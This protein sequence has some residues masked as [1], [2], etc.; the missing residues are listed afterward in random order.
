MLTCPC[1][2]AHRTTVQNAR[3]DVMIRIAVCR[4]SPDQEAV[5]AVVLVA[6]VPDLQGVPAYGLANLRTLWEAESAV[7]FALRSGAHQ[8]ELLG[9]GTS[10][11]TDATAM[12]RVQARPSERSRS[13]V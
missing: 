5:R 6:N 7:E 3:K 4:L 12:V 11:S 8:Q 9:R 13:K 1:R 10:S 2:T